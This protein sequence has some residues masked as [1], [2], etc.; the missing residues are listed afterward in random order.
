MQIAKSSILGRKLY[1]VLEKRPGKID[2]INPGIANNLVEIRL[3]LHYTHAR[4]DS[5][6]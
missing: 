2:S 3:S 6:A 5:H 4:D 1:A